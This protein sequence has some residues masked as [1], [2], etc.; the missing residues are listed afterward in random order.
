MAVFSTILVQLVT[1][2]L[3]TSSSNSHAVNGTEV[4]YG[5]I[6]KQASQQNIRRARY[7]SDADIGRQSQ[8]QPLHGRELYLKLLM[9]KKF[10]HTQHYSITV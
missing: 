2:S 4:S 5:W 8:D 9:V 6:E 1:D 10:S 3:A 7:L